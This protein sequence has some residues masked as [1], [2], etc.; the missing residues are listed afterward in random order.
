[1]RGCQSLLEGWGGL[2]L[3]FSCTSGL[4]G[5]QGRAFGL[6][7]SGAG[8]WRSEKGIQAGPQK[9]LLHLLFY[10]LL[11]PCIF[12]ARLTPPLS[13]K[14]SLSLPAS[15]CFTVEP[16]LLYHSVLV[17][18]FLIVCH[19]PGHTTWLSLPASHRVPPGQ[20]LAPIR[21]SAFIWWIHEAYFSGRISFP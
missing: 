1:M 4:Q 10:L 2:G 3:F 20:G 15:S 19:T 12:V 17:W 13:G 14:H 11:S 16:L 5:G 8:T 18:Y 6:R 9:H 7:E 21:F